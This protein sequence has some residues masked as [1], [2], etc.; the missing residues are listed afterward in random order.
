VSSDAG[1]K[2]KS[3]D[4]EVATEVEELDDEDDWQRW[5]N[6][7]YGGAIDPWDDLEVKENEEFSD[8]S[9]HDDLDQDDGSD[10]DEIDVR[11]MEAPPCPAPLG[12]IHVI[13]LG[14]CNHCLSRISGRA[15]SGVGLAEHGLTIRTEMIERD[16]DLATEDEDAWCP[17]CEDLFED[18][19]SIAKRL[20]DSLSEVEFEEI[21][22]GI[23]LPKDLLQE[24]DRLR[25]KFGAAGSKPLKSSFVDAIHS[26]LAEIMP[27]VRQVKERPEVMVLIDTLTLRVDIDVRPVYIY[28]RYRKLERGIPQ[29]RWPCRACRGREGGCDSC[30]GSG[31]QYPNSVQDLLGEPARELFGGAETSFHGMGRED[32]DV[33]CLGRGRPFVL[34]I[35]QP[36]VRTADLDGLTKTIKSETDGKVEVSD[37]RLSMR[38]EVAR[39]KETK[40]EKSYTI[41]FQ[42]EG[43]IADE[44]SA[45]SAVESLGGVVLAQKTPTRVAH[46]RAD[47]VRERKVAEVS[48]VSVDGDEMQFQVRCQTGTYVKELVHS[49]EGRT[50]PSVA[51]LIGA[52]CEVLWLDVEEIHAE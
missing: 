40:A 5:A 49:D 9:E 6:A 13:R 26:S 41:R 4:G 21:Q 22:I 3:A 30:E 12:V 29:T 50:E 2:P 25:T 39:I 52:P 15:R 42:V 47:K 7:D 38:S 18:A 31:L 17:F 45:I 44:E 34:E 1:K 46:R 36:K 19:P 24:E 35:K 11:D 16:P 28:G 48:E 14:A 43:G 32:I 37:L 8:N 51:A 27:K 10:F 23:H 20:T 33:R